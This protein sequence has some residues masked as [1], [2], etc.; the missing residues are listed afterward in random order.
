MSEEFHAMA[1]GI[2]KAMLKGRAWEL[3]ETA[4][5]LMLLPTVLLLNF[6]EGTMAK[7]AENL[8]HN[9]IALEFIKICMDEGMVQARKEYEAIKV[10]MIKNPN[11]TISQIIGASRGPAQKE[12]I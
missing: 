10:E 3:Q 12:K 4:E 7:G 5:F 2:L 1:K 9:R 8:N 6:L 11:R